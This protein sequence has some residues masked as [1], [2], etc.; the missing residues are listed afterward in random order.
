METRVDVVVVG[1]GV[2]GG[3][4][5]LDNAQRTNDAFIHY[6]EERRERMRRLRFM[7]QQS[8]ILRAEFTDAARARR[9]RVRERVAANP[10]IALPSGRY[11]RPF[12][13]A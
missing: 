8:S 5:L 1:A 4:A 6:V 3:E 12:W 11:Q 7:A 9:L 2:A 10:S 13:C